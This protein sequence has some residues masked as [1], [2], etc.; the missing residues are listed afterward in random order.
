MPPGTT[1]QR[2][3]WNDLPGRM[4]AKMNAARTKRK[5]ELAKI[6][7]RSA[8]DEHIA[9]LR[10]RVWELIGGRPDETPLNARTMGT[11][12]RH[13]YRIEKVIF[14]S[15]PEFHVTGN[16][17][18]PTSGAGRSPAI[19]APLGHTSEGKTY[20]SYQT[21]FQNLARKGFV[22]FTWDP[23]GQGERLQYIEPAPTVHFMGRRA[24]M[25]D[26]DGRRCLSA[27]PP[28]NSRSGMAF[29]RLITC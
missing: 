9:M 6:K 14:E 12:E 3:Y 27:P 11:I 20:R 16:L 28:R 1:R 8:A 13:A 19:L 2:D 21:V 23:I 17:Y 25:I 7:S 26:S 24:N 29:G 18:L 4:I 22:V 15:Q 10:S 5:S